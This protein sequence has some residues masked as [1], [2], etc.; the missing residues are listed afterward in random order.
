MIDYNRTTT[1]LDI[2]LVSIEQSTQEAYNYVIGGN[3]DINRSFSILAEIGLG[4]RTSQM[5][6]FTY[7]F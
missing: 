1:D 4:K 5:L 6:S 2:L 3:W 7:R